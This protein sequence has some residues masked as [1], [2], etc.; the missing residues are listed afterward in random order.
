[1]EQLSLSRTTYCEFIG[2][3]LWGSWIPIQ[4]YG[5]RALLREP[6]EQGGVRVEREDLY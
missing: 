6:A 3:V 4:V 5:G 2:I 1:M